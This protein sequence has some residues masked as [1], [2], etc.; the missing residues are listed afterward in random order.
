M[1]A[2]FRWIGTA[3]GCLVLAGVVFGSLIE[4]GVVPS[5][6]VLSGE[7][8]PPDQVAVLRSEGIVDEGEVV[9]YFYSEGLFSVRE[10]GSILTDKRVIA[11]EANRMDGVDI[12]ELSLDEIESVNLTQPGDSLS[13]T[14]YTVN[15]QSESDWLD[16]WLPHEHGDGELFVNAVRARIQ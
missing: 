12:Y 1:G 10:G 6:R 11:Y 14:V 3:C 5:D 13:F 9:E 2:L 15:G 8:I 4:A 16:L 7:R